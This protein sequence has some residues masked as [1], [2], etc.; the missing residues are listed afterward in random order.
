MRRMWFFSRALLSEFSRLWPLTRSR[1]R[2][3]DFN[4]RVRPLLSDRCFHCHGRMKSTARKPNC[5]SDLPRSMPTAGSTISAMAPR[6]TAAHSRGSRPTTR[7]TGC[8]RK[9][10]A[11]NCLRQRSP[12]IR[13]QI[14]GKARKW[15]M[16]W[17][18]VASCGMIRQPSNKPTVRR[19]IDNTFCLE[20][21]GSR[22]R[23]MPTGAAASSF[24]RSVRPAADAAEVAAFVSD[25]SPNAQEKVVDR[26]LAS[27]AH[28]ASS[29][30]FT[31][32][33]WSIR[34]HRRLSR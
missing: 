12:L 10:L 28:V 17:A 33:T 14:P 21:E 1:G 11:R 4:S 16:H 31:G 26:L 6:T 18:Y 5:S 34:G 32:S 27:E 15:D 19:A 23:P 22:R 7:G 8:L 3:V 25:D 13:R 30:P 24:I 9:V 2:A 29:S 20:R